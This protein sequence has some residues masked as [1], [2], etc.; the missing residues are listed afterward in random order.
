MMILF[1]IANYLLGGSSEFLYYTGYALFLGGMLFTKTYYDYRI[2]N[3]VFFMEA[4]LDF[5]MQCTGIGFYMVF[6]QKFLSTRIKYPFL[7]KLY[8]T[9]IVGL[10]ISVLLFSYLYFFCW[11]K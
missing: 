5:V 2:N 4:Y 6:M 3:D 9:G 8:N 10:I 7:H 11:Y 1:S